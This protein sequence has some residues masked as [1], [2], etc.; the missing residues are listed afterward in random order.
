MRKSRGKYWIWLFLAIGILMM[1]VPLQE[2][3]HKLRP[4]TF[5]PKREGGWESAM[6]IGPTP[7]VIAALGGFRTVA[8]DLLWL[9]A[10]RAWDGGSWWAIVPLLDTVTQLDPHFILAWKVYGWHC[11]YN[12]NVESETLVDKRYWLQ[13]GLNVL[14]KAVEANPDRWE[15]YFELGWTYYDRA[16]EPYRASEW[17]YKADQFPDAPSYVTRFYYRPFE[18]IMDFDALFP[19]MEYAKKKHLDDPQHQYLVKRDIEWW[20]THKD[21]PQEHRRQIVTEN[22]ARKQRALPFYLYPNDPYWDVCPVCGIPSPKGS[23]TCQYCGAPL[24]PRSGSA[25]ASPGRTN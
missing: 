21:D 7:A 9:R 5:G 19:R 17:F 16:H 3:I 18:R 4:A 25:A 14:E 23:E 24:H 6:R 1:T 2:S 22:T 13:R 10:E 8:A 15:M 11:A 20:T 12:L